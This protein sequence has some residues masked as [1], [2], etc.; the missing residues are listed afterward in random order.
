M[1]ELAALDM[2][3]HDLGMDLS[4]GELLTIRAAQLRIEVDGED[5]REVMKWVRNELGTH[6]RVTVSDLLQLRANGL[7][8]RE[9][10]DHTGLPRSTV[11]DWLSEASLAA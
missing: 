1:D 9:I 4:I 6:E 11:H 10:A 8:L 3:A 7:S 2:K 5:P